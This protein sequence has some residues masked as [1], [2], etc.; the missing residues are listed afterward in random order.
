[1]KQ[2]V[3]SLSTLTVRG[4]DPWDV[5]DCAHACGYTH[6]GFR[7]R[8]VIDGEPLLAI[9]G[10]A[11]R[12]QRITERM[13]ATGIK[14]LDIEFFW[15]RPDTHVTDFEPYFEAAAQ[16][17]ASSV[18]CGGADPER[19]RFLDRWIEVCDLAAQYELRAHLEFMPM[20]EVKT[21]ADGI[22]V[23]KAAPHPRAGLM[24]DPLH[25]DRGGSTASEILPE[26]WKYFGYAQLCDGYP[27]R[28]TSLE[29]MQRQAKGDRLAPGCGGIDLVGILRALP[30][31]LPL[32]IEA[33]VAATERWPAYRRAQYVFDATQ[34][35]LA[36]AYAGLAA[37]P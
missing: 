13:R 17:G 12:M 36:R 7:F 6:A 35:L 11:D 37:T 27:E 24:I 29:E 19:F 28:P 4:T 20:T 15:I 22:S 21:Y 25:F 1:M 23:M 10:H 31:D 30:R 18:L 14:V 5:V 16:L 3:L 32:S 9:V 33:P 34:E 2:R 8:P 26:H